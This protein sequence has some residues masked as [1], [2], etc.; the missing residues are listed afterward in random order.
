MTLPIPLDAPVTN[1]TLPC[2][3]MFRSPRHTRRV[4]A[5]NRSWSCLSRSSVRK[6]LAPGPE[7]SHPP[8]A[9]SLRQGGGYTSC[10]TMAPVMWRGSSD[11]RHSEVPCCA[12]QCSWTAA[13]VR[14]R[15]GETMVIVPEIEL[16]LGPGRWRLAIRRMRVLPG[17]PTM[18]WRAPRGRVEPGPGSNR[19]LAGRA[20]PGEQM[21]R[22]NECDY[23]S[24]RRAPC[25]F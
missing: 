11:A 13:A 20:H 5:A 19:P 12:G 10:L 17:R 16:A 7:G 18:K 2:K 9:S 8:M 22:P 21:P 14:P 4:C 25:M 23:D 6:T 15:R 3:L 24:N 1:A